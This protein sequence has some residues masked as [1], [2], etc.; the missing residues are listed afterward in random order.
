MTQAQISKGLVIDPQDQNDILI[1]VCE[2]TDMNRLM[3]KLPTRPN[4]R[5]S[6]LGSNFVF[7]DHWSGFPFQSL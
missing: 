6:T 5:N 7:V 1:F 3:I 2:L 4:V